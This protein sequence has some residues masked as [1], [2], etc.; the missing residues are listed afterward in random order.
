[1]IG[2]AAHEGGG[3]TSRSGGS[4]REDDLKGAVGSDGGQMV[5]ENKLKNLPGPR[6]IGPGHD[7]ETVQ[8]TR[9]GQF[10]RTSRLC[11]QPGRQSARKLAASKQ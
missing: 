5:V 11:I 3:E 1:M 7:E 9:V 4:I 2:N 10:P 8:V 6:L